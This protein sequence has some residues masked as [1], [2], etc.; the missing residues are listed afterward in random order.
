VTTRTAISPPLPEDAAYKAVIRSKLNRGISV[1]LHRVTGP[2]Q[3]ESETL[4]Y[5]GIFH[6]IGKVPVIC[7]PITPYQTSSGKCP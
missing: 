5:A 4:Y 3:A 6:D 7:G 1:F 2:L